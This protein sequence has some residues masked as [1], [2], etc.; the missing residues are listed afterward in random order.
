MADADPREIDLI[1]V[2]TAT[3]DYLMPSTACLVQNALGAMHAG[4]FDLNAGCS[5]FVYALT[6]GPAGHRVWGD[7][8]WC[9]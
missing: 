4:A 3:P 8:S 7:Q 6:A 2:A 5:G 9:W 1:I